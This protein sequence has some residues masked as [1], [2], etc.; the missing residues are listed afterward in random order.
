MEKEILIS[1]I[2]P[3]Y[4]SENFLE[5][6]LES[7]TKQ[8][9]KN[10]EVL[11]I[12]DG[13]TDKSLEICNFFQRKYPDMIRIFN[14]KNQGVSASRNQGINEAKGK[15]LQFIDSDDWIEETM[16]E[17][18]YKKIKEEDSDIVVSGYI[19]EEKKLNFS[20]KMIPITEE[21]D[22]YFWL[23]D[24]ALIPYV[25]SKMYK[26]EKILDFK[27]SFEREIQLSED[28]LFNIEYMLMSQKVSILQKAF[29][30]YIIH[31][32]NT[33]LNI[34]KRKDIFKV[35]E[36]ID[37]FLIQNR[38][39]KNKEILSKIRIIKERHTKSALRMLLRSNNKKEFFEY[40]GFFKKNISNIKYLSIRNKINI[41]IRYFL[42][43]WIYLL[44]LKRIVE[45]RDKIYFKIKKWRN[46]KNII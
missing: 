19:K 31:D 17:E 32:N 4:N 24:K 29:Y 36:K 18:T 15:Y 2:I 20:L 38:K 40:I 5:K 25:S 1:V 11:L 7:V 33:V 13:S 12:N 46:N 23:S 3:V 28:M 41:Y 34:E 16:L 43:Y 42:I 44:N 26:K 39:N 37:N 30:H 22:K 21:N 10:F 14:N 9:L 27:L 35:F 8:T 45:I 6:C